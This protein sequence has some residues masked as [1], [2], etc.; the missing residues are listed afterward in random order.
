MRYQDYGS[1]VDTGL[2]LASEEVV[3]ARRQEDVRKEKEA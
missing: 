1:T 3:Q 2:L